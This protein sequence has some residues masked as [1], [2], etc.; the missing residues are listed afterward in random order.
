MWSNTYLVDLLIV[1]I[2]PKP[3]PAAL[4]ITKNIHNVLQGVSPPSQRITAEEKK[5]VI[6]WITENAYRYWLSESGPL[7][8]VE[9]GGAHIIIVCVL[10]V[11]CL[12]VQFLPH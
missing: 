5:A 12:S 9:E 8:P 7:C 11:S 3:L 4:R 6:H 10:L 1:T 2:V